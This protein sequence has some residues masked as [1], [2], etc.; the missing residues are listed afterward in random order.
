[1]PKTPARGLASTGAAQPV[2]ASIWNEDLKPPAQVVTCLFNPNTFSI[3]KTSTWST[4]QCQGEDVPLAMFAGGGAATLTID[5]L[6][7]DTYT[8][9]PQRGKEDKHPPSVR[10]YTDKVVKLT[11]IDPSLKDPKTQRARPPRVTFRWGSWTSFKAVVTSVNQRF[12]LFMAN[13]TPV[14]ATLSVTLQEVSES[15]SYPGTNPTS[16][17]NV[18]RVHRVNP[19]EMIDTVA[20]KF[21]GDASKWTLIAD[22]NRLSDPLR[23]T[24]GQLLAIPDAR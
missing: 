18:Q 20:F 21:Y 12:T 19:G 2:K 6:L 14:R 1:M 10:D 13:G 15:D 22:H 8:L 16:R 4:E 9:E 11:K 23:L 24:A 3:N 5:E 7:F 17:A